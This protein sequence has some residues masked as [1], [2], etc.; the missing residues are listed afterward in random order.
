[1]QLSK[2]GL[3]PASEDEEAAAL[4]LE[5]Q[6]DS[7][8]STEG[9]E[10]DLGADIEAEAAE[11][12]DGD[13]P[14][15]PA[16]NGSDDDGDGDSDEEDDRLDSETS[17]G[18]AEIE[19]LEAEMGDLPQD[20]ELGAV[21]NDLAE[22]MNASKKRQRF[23]LQEQLKSKQGQ[24]ELDLRP[25]DTGDFRMKII[26]VN[27]TS[28]GARAGRVQGVSAL[29]VVGNN[30]GILGHGTG[31][32][33]EAKQAV[34]KATRRALKSLTYVP[35]FRGHTIYYPTTV[36]FGKS[37]LIM[38]P[39][40]SNRGIMA[41]DLLRSVCLLAGL[42]DLG[43]KI[44]GSRNVRNVV[45]CLFKAF[46]QMH[47]RVDEDTIDATPSPDWP[48]KSYIQWQQSKLERLLKEAEVM[49][50]ETRAEHKLMD[51]WM[52]QRAA[53]GFTAPAEDEREAH[54]DADQPQE[55]PPQGP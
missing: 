4:L 55:A 30:D 11:L 27:R 45:K 29:V 25:P 44:Q 1:V 20:S 53:R 28:K 51:Q 7:A 9:D 14:D 21:S 50:A 8:L 3:A 35:R 16:G 38:Y 46:A 32:A 47:A 6:D 37:K 41:S 43:I 17:I 40:A 33:A 54:D 15:A 10:E 52:A 42:K 31:K 18:E 39:R 23:L 2:W 24:E 5:D 36:L 48:D 22:I 19:R 12:E 13:I 34:D 49:E 26:D